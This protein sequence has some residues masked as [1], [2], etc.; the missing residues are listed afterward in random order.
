MLDEA[1]AVR[2]A[3]E[4]LPKLD[5]ET[6]R[7]TW[8][9][10]WYRWEH[11]AVKL[12]RR[13]TSEHKA[14]AQLAK[15]PW[16]FLVVTT[17]AQT[18]FVDGYRSTSD[19]SNSNATPWNTWLAN[20]LAARQIPIHRAGLAYGYAYEVV[21]PGA[22]PLT[23]A[24]QAVMRGVSPRRMFAAYEDPAEDD[25]PEYALR[26]DPGDTYRLYDDA[27]VHRL[28]R[29]ESGKLAH[30]GFSVHDIGVCPV[31]RFTPDLDLEGRATGQVE[32]YIGTAKRINKDVYD[33]LLVQHHN[34]WK[35]RT[36]AGLAEPEGGAEA[37]A[38][39]KLQLRQDDILV[40]EDSDTKFGTLAETPLDGFVKVCEADIEALAAVSQ[41]P[42]HAL[43][44]KMINLSAEALSAAR[45]ALSQ[46]V[47]E[48]TT[49]FGESH[50]RALRL[51]ALIE[52]NR[53][54]AAD[55]T[56]R[57][58]WQDMD[59]RSLAQ[60][61]DALGKAA[62]MLGVPPRALW[63]RMPGVTKTDVE[64]WT[65]MVLSDDPVDRFLRDNFADPSQ[66]ADAGL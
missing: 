31:V 42:S 4:L 35:I 10:K 32:P 61:V 54:D 55:A 7:L 53:T 49:S 23:G 30:A 28:I 44:G 20:G 60:A 58:T 11:E 56:A 27:L 5:R 21:T 17:L 19:A 59:V 51:A 34:S 14:L 64:E 47:F 65:E 29:S 15:T 16:L 13:S 66:P 37:A 24:K 36:I 18:M 8:I 39:K 43:T 45:A 2:V 6:A 26:R 50:G 38:A 63:A 57:V 62:Q 48:I 52:G 9:D 1:D 25:W 22:S 40:A 41:T 3:N 46:K 12:P 33:R